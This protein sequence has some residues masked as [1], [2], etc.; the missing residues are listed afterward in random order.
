[1][2]SKSKNVIRARYFII[3]F[4]ALFLFMIPGLFHS[5]E[6]LDMERKLMFQTG[7]AQAIAAHKA[8][9]S[10]IVYDVGEKGLE[11]YGHCWSTQPDP[12]LG[13]SPAIGFGSMEEGTGYNSLLDD[14]MPDTKY[15]MRS[16]VKAKNGEVEYGAPF[17]FHTLPD[18]YD[19]FMPRSSEAVGMY[20]ANTL[21]IDGVDSEPEWAT[22]QAYECSGRSLDMLVTEY[23]PEDLSC[24]FKVLFN[25][26]GIM[27][28][29]MVK[30]EIIIPFDDVR[31]KD[32]PPQYANFMSEVQVW[33]ADFA[34]IYLHW[35]DYPTPTGEYTIDNTFQIRFNPYYSTATL[36]EDI[37]AIGM[38]R[39]GR[40]LGLPSEMYSFIDFVVVPAD[41]GYNAE[42]FISWDLFGDR[43]D[44]LLYLEVQAGDA[45]DPDVLR[46]SL[47][48]WNNTDEHTLPREIAW[49]NINFL[50]RLLLYRPQF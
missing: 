3:T 16:Y 27:F 23:P 25:E 12:I 7:E 6:Y 47:V 49:S 35:G 38:G 22:T 21:V 14:L 18:V 4:T 9:V 28:W 46:E 36:P 34:E 50:G 29:I 40:D 15:F 24:S 42:A 31:H 33:M 1:M 39:Y 43:P 30:D 5:C 32:V 11:Q 17:E 8:I 19:L 10:G 48:S 26:E 20:T 2:M 13:N 44:N 45:D 37:D 41:G